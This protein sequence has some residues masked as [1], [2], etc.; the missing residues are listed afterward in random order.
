MKGY[1]GAVILGLA[2]FLGLFGIVV[3]TVKIP[4]GYVGVIYS[5]NGGVAEN[6]LSQG[7]HLVSPTKHVTKYTVGIEQSYLT[8]ENKGDS[9]KDES[10]TASSSEGKAVNL[11]LTFTYQYD[12]TRVS[13]VF[14]KF[15]G[16]SGE[17]VKDSFIK[18]NVISWTKEVVSRYKVADMLGEKRADI[19]SEI[20]QYLAE[21]S[22]P[23]GI[24]ISN[25]SLINI[26]VDK[27]TEKAINDKIK[28][29]QDAERQAV[30]NQMNIDKATA[31]AEARRIKAQGKADALL[32]E[33][34]A[35]AEANAKVS[36][37]LTDNIIRQQYIDKWN[38]KMPTYNGGG[39]NTIV[40][41]GNISE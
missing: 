13:E 38:G 26:S 33:A 2:L 35:E 1:I 6:T 23:Y 37:S 36:E 21:K 8:S 32:I 28:A 30:E 11:D 31:D 4:A 29:T 34:Q 14:T 5:M 39:S 12:A 17:E 22:E 16:K 7:W 40:D 24:I 20:T 41:L 15:K 9:E 3:C 19:N 10:F 27:Q 18:P 25:A